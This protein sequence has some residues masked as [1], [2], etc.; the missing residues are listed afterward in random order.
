M[1]SFSSVNRKVRANSKYTI[2]YKR[3]GT[4]EQLRLQIEDFDWRKSQAASAFPQ[5]TEGK[6][7]KIIRIRPIRLSAKAVFLI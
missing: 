5:R 1:A 2:K 6:E 3:E 7:Q 4:A